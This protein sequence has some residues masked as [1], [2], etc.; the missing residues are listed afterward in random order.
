MSNGPLNLLVFREDSRCVSG[1]QLKTDLCDALESCS[2][3]CGS[4]SALLLAGELEC[5]IA[6]AAP[7]H[8]S[9]FDALTDALAGALV[10]EVILDPSSLTS[11]LSQ[12]P[13]PPELRIAKFEGFA[14]Y[15]LH[16]L[17]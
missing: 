12:L 11:Q 10:G 5:G 14:Y 1:P 3:Q 13:V 15:A 7:Q 9:G 2:A 4:L 16:P 6:D 17:G 8:L